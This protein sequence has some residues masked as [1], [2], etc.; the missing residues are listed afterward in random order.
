MNNILVTMGVQELGLLLRAYRERAGLRQEDLEETSGVSQ[1]MIS[2]LERGAIQRPNMEFI[3]AIAAA[4]DAPYEEL[5]EALHG[6]RVSNTAPS[7][8]L[9]N[10]GGKLR[11]LTPDELRS[12]E[13]FADFVR[14]K[15]ERP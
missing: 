11:D 3:R 6:A 1:G 14:S 15:R 2:R 4:T 12:V 13:E 5:V 7:A 9:A 10:L 8:A